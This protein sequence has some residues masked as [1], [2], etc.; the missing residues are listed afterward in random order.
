MLYACLVIQGVQ[1][2]PL[3]ILER[4][5]VFWGVIASMYVG[6]AAL[7]LLNFPLVGLWVSVLRIPQSIL[8]ALI[9]LLTLVGAYSINNSL[10]DLA[11]LVA[12]GMIGYIFRKLRL[13]VS[14][15]V[16]ALVLGP[17]LENNFRQS[18]FMSR[19]D[20]LI[21]L[22]RPISMVFLILL[23]LVMIGPTL[24]RSFAKSR[25]PS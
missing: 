22:Q 17:M 13:D 2:G 16:V 11:V 6:N 24:V 7:L 12:F 10:L 4:P 25:Q 15:L 20:L 18:L 23:A 19:G 9:L 21:F 1:T 5:A 8:L 14:P 3:L